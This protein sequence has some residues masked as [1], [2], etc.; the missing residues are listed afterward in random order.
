MSRDG[1]VL[2]ASGIAFV[3]LSPL[4]MIGL[5]FWL[6]IG[7]MRWTARK[8]EPAVQRWQDIF[9]FDPV[10][11]WKA[12]G[13]LD[14][15]VLEDRDDVFHV[16][17]DRFGWAGRATIDESDVIVVGDSHA[18]GY[19]VD[20]GKAFFNL[21]PGLRIKTI[22]APGY[23]LVQELLLLE[24]VA[25]Q[26]QGK[27]VVW[28]VY[29][30][31]DLFDNLTPEIDGYRTP[32]VRQVQGGSRWDIVTHHLS[33]TKWTCSDNV[34]LRRV[35]ALLAALHSETS[36]A[37]RAYDACE[38]LLGRGSRLCRE[39]GAELVVLS[40]PAIVTISESHM[41]A[42][43]VARSF[44]MPVD[45]GLPDRKLSDMCARLGIRYES[46]TSRLEVRHYKER[47]DHWTEEGHRQVAAVLWNLYSQFRTDAGTTRSTHSD[48]Q[49][50][51]SVSH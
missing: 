4:L 9:E 16:V 42:M 46:L 33:P 24:Q 28:F 31:N 14:C 19:G 38:F 30:G 17:T 34:K 18:W 5:P 51:V 23:N 29:I 7:L 13:N 20:H 36:F 11:G 40:I 26:L 50:L 39:V 35:Y 41:R 49:R 22:G 3:V 47:D 44:H 1:L 2:L 48:D 37:K 43:C 15:H 45:R 10:L 25:P 21:N 27:L 12:K 6:A 32:F 8:M